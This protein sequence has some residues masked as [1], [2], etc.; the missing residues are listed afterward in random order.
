MSDAAT[1]FA[2]YRFRP[3]VA[4][5]Q[6]ADLLSRHRTAL[7]GSGL[8]T[9]T[10]PV[11][12]RSTHTHPEHK[13]FIEI[14]E[15]TNADAPAAAHANSAVSQIWHE[16]STLTTTPT[17]T[18]SQ[19]AEASHPWAHFAPFAVGYSAAS[20]G[21]KTVAAGKR[22]ST[23][24]KTKTVKKAAASKVAKKSARKAAPKAA[25]KRAAQKARPAAKAKRTMPKP[26]KRA[27]ARR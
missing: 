8:V 10:R 19:L 22:A 1:V 14:F 20:N 6:I 26:K 11:V 15:W 24:K 18:L 25:Q 3:D 16:F 5:T 17:V 23:A 13:D 7:E 4:D 9:G 12:V 27:M 2:I 21:A